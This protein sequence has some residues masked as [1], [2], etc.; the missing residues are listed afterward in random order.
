MELPTPISAVVRS[1]SANVQQQAKMNE[2]SAPA[3]SERK[4][5]DIN[6]NKLAKPQLQLLKSTSQNTDQ[7]TNKPVRNVPWKGGAE[8][9]PQYSKNMKIVA[10]APSNCNVDSQ[11][12]GSDKVV[13][14][15]LKNYDERV[16][17]MNDEKFV[18]TPTKQADTK[19]VLKNML[20]NSFALSKTPTDEEING[21]WEAVR[22]YLQQ[23][24]DDVTSHKEQASY[25]FPQGSH[26]LSRVSPAFQNSAVSGRPSSIIS[27]PMYTPSELQTTPGF[28][29]NTK[30]QTSATAL[31][32]GYTSKQTNQGFSKPSPSP[33]QTQLQSQ[34]ETA[35]NVTVVAE[36]R[37]GAANKARM[38]PVANKPPRHPVGTV[39]KVST[40][41]QA[42]LQQYDKSRSTTQPTGSYL[43]KAKRAKSALVKV[44]LATLSEH[45][46]KVAMLKQQA[47]LPPPSQVP[48]FAAKQSSSRQR[49]LSDSDQGL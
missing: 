9:Q 30:A 31:R 29:E 34:L 23:A 7:A 38:I 15:L 43:A 8:S 27:E 10:A 11:K 41:A 22:T 37:D 14:Y 1:G 21:L 44:T 42:Q 47:T 13:G 3:A 16:D 49:R 36:K 20:V 26:I 18:T 12:K 35:N 5:A 45:S 33:I 24:R 39:N 32:S 48:P 19:E 25:L 40:T 6:E 28:S 4:R 46:K 17:N 2:V